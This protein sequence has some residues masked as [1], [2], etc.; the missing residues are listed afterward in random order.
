MAKQA[1]SA[2]SPNVTFSPE[3]LRAVIAQAIAEHEASKAQQAKADTSADM[4]RLC[5]KAFVKQ[6]YAAESVK[7]RV[8]CLTFNKWLAKGFR[9][10]EGEK[11][12][13]IKGLRLFH[14][15]QV[16]PLGAEDAEMVAA[17]AARGVPV[18]MPAKPAPKA[19]AAKGKSQPQPA[20]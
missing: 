18:T 20:A 17:K 19:K 7:P 12:V 6:G 14:Q 3:Q 2:A 5:V 13:A 16:R 15:D 11:A 9:P 10:K 8:N 1:Q 4:D